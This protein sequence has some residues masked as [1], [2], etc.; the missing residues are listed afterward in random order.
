MSIFSSLLKSPPGIFHYN[1][2]VLTIHNRS[3]CQ[4]LPT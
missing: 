3:I 2:A 4:A 1:T